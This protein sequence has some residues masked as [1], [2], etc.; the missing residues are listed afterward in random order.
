MDPRGGPGETP[1]AAH[2]GG[3][4]PRPV[5]ILRTSLG[6][7][8]CIVYDCLYPHTVGGAERWYRTLAGELAAGGHEVSYLT[9]RQWE[10]EPAPIPGVRIVAVAPGGPLYTDGGRR[11]VG[12][13]LRF[14]AGVLVHLLRRRR[15]YDVVHTCAFPYF[16]LLGAR[17]ALAGSRTAVGVEWFEVWS[18]AY[19]REYLG[20]LGGRIGERVQRLCVRLTPRAFV[21]S[22]LHGERL[23]EQGLRGE[24]VVLE[25]LYDGPLEP[26][27][28]ESA[29][30][31]VVF[32][33][34]HI[35]EKRVTAIPSVVACARRELPGLRALVLGDG[36]ERP[37]LLAAIDAAG[38]REA[39]DAPGFVGADEVAA[40]L[41][42][43]TCLLLPSVREGYGM[44]VIEAAAA[45]TPSVVAAAP[46]NAAIEL[47]EPG[48]NGVRAAGPDPEALAA[49]IVEVHRG[50]A[51]LRASTREWFA[52]N[53]RRL[54]AR[55]SARHVAAAYE[56]R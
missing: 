43:A 49:A 23:R 36:P 16:A 35:P 29:E 6:V 2:E 12:P 13:P 4:A 25:G 7:R 38:V 14:G 21:F 46:D 10:G 19:W 17:L 44:V 5:A 20:A 27:A 15:S 55:E 52:R 1:D 34:R 40:A 56:E 31:L 3:V 51:A 54:A 28:D 18:A 33:G 39:V 11:R 24:P 8:I 47:I 53:A 22:A 45:G 42:R 26:V 30:P 37:A 50:G 32:A 41:R 48:V 9:R